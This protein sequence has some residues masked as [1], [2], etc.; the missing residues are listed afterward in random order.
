MVF[1][2]GKN[3][4][5]GDF[6]LTAPVAPGH[7]FISQNVVVCASQKHPFGREDNIKIDLR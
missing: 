3:E 4:S 7:N 6:K 2:S 5:K 1:T